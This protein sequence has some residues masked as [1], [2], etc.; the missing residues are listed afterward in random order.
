MSHEA[1][2]VASGIQAG[3]VQ[4]HAHFCLA[5]CWRMRLITYADL[6]CFRLQS[7]A[8]VGFP[9]VS[10]VIVGVAASRWIADILHKGLRTLE[11]TMHGDCRLGLSRYDHTAVTPAKPSRELVRR[12][13]C[14]T[15]A[16]PAR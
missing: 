3:A 14:S 16:R 7:H 15:T 12:D 1:K 8:L 10:W 5:L 13:L 6:W 11:Q 9:K 2:A 4:C